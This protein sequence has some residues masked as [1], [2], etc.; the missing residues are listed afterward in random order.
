MYQNSDQ[1]KMQ[2]IFMACGMKD[3]VLGPPVMKSLSKIWKNGCL[4][5]EV[6]DGGHFVQEWGEEVARVAIES[7]ESQADLVQG[8][9]K[10][11]PQQ[12]KM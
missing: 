3:P 11:N 5:T 2:D 12:A 10:I 1:F 7:F 9:Q 8:V 6:A 4:W